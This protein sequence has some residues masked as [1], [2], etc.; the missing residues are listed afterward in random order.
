[1][2]S[3]SR[4]GGLFRPVTALGV[5]LVLSMAVGGC[6]RRPQQ[7]EG[8][9]PSGG[10]GTAGGATQPVEAGPPPEDWPRVLV[11]GP[12]SGPALFLGHADDAPAVGYLNPGVRIRLESA[13]L[14]GRVEVL[15]AGALATKGWIPTGRLAAYAQ[16]RGR[17][18]GT[19]AY[20]GPNDM[21]GILGPA[22]TE[23]QMRVEVRPWLGG[24][25]F[26]GPFVGTYSSELLADEEVD[27]TTVE[28]VSEG[29]CF[30]LPAGQTVTVYDRPD[31]EAVANIP[32]QD[33]PLAV[34]RLIA[35]GGWHG[36]RAGY[37]PYLTG[38]VSDTLTPCE[39]AMPAPEPMVPSSEGERP[40]WMEQE[41]G[42]LHR[43]A[44]G[45][46]VQF[47]G[48]TVARLRAPGWARE[49][50][51]QGDDMVDVFV[52]VDEQTALRGLVPASSL[53]L[54]EGEATQA[55]T[56]AG[57]GGAAEPSPP[58]VEQEEL[59]PELQ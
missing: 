57:G 59:P 49:L 25:N 6:R 20:L 28:G 27:E 16:E 32:A 55:P 26:L 31:G 44:E 45:T 41:S 46:R 48:R 37:G 5:L 53:T 14:N 19:R 18:E 29:E 4:N 40:F 33:P 9:A 22:Q 35:R 42:P 1:M 8:E 54:V 11:V 38:F 56:P 34:T 24:S 3:V 21:V 47:H 36:I 50:G 2:Q 12:G 15:V 30:R 52:A 10:I 23:G 43:V 17:V 51:R 39:G 7:A 13:P 58:P